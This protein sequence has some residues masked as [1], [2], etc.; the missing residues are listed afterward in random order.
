MLTNRKRSIYIRFKNISLFYILYFLFIFLIYILQCFARLKILKVS[1]ISVS[2]EISILTLME[3]VC[4][5]VFHFIYP[6]VLGK[7][8]VPFTG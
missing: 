8:D 7:V 2:H 6:I 1:N 4:M 5:S 3:Y